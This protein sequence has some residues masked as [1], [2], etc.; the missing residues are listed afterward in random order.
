MTKPKTITKEKIALMLKT[1]LGLSGIMCEEL[2]DKIFTTIYELSTE[3]KKLTIQEFGCFF[4]HDKKERQ[5]RDIYAKKS[6]TV[7]A[8]TIFKFSPAKSLREKINDA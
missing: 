6:V 7:P 8:R 4:M 2:V 5:G 1:K 3:H